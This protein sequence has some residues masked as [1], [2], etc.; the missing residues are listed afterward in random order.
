MTPPVLRVGL[1]GLGNVGAAFA[2]ALLAREEQIIRSTGARLALAQIAVHNPALLR[3]GTGVARVHGDGARIAEDGS[4]DLVIEASGATPASGWL[5][6]ALARGAVVVCANKQALARDPLLLAALARGEPR[7]LCEASVAA[8][9]PVVRALR[10]S[11][12][13][14]EILAIRGVL[15]GTTTFILAR[16]ERG[17]PFAR[18][19]V[20][21]QQAGYAEA[22][23]AADLSGLDA[24]AKLAILATIAWR[25][26]VTIDDIGVHGI[27]EG[28]AHDVAAAARLR[29]RV[30]LVA[31]ASRN[32]GLHA[33]VRPLALEPDDALSGASGV[34][35]VVEVRAALA[36]TLTWS[37]PGA[38]GVSTA[39][40]L[41]GDVL[42]A[43][44][45]LV[46][47]RDG[48]AAA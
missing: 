32:G 27:A 8:A 16:L 38:G 18:A 10:E 20:E 24:A 12:A 48:R 33:S 29:Q 21:A 47:E 4:L 41:L 39:S 7:L 45:G 2:H 31:T 15:N 17:V 30:R 36:G 14:E 13:G 26:P 44:R 6:T 46:R 40:A 9:V 22:D 5:R 19:V 35:N 43:A 42:A 11:L 1:I 37:G 34:H 28:I 23:P 25:A 3:T